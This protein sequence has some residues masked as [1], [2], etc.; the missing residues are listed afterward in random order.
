MIHTI[1]LPLC[2][3][4]SV[5]TISLSVAVFNRIF[6]FGKKLQFKASDGSARCIDRQV[7]VAVNIDKVGPLASNLPNKIPPC[8][9]SVCLT[10]VE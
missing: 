8:T 1:P 5:E 4:Q 2:V 3:Q 9:P 10:S 7:L 6:H